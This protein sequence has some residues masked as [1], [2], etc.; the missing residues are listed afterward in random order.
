MNKSKKILTLK[1]YLK[2]LNIKMEIFQK[3]I[4]PDL[5]L[6]FKYNNFIQV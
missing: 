3:F 1:R 4:R 2:S 6:Y 5:T